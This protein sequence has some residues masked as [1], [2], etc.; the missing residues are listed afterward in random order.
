MCVNLI[1]RH[2]HYEYS[3]WIL[4][5]GMTGRTEEW[6]LVM[7]PG[8]KQARGHGEHLCGRNQGMT[9]RCDS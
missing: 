8:A 7:R 9:A 6:A 5:P 1:P 4:K 3:V 2:T